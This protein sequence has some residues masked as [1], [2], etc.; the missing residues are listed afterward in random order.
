MRFSRRLPHLQHDHRTIRDREVPFRAMVFFSPKKAM[1]DEGSR[2]DDSD[3]CEE[4]LSQAN[5]QFRN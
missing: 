5:I 1:N 4:G 3:L 2:L